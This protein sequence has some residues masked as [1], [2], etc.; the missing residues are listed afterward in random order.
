LHFWLPKGTV[1]EHCWLRCTRPSEN[2]C[3]TRCAFQWSC[4]TT[5]HRWTWLRIVWG[6][7]IPSLVNN[8]SGSGVSNFEPIST[9]HFFWK[10][11]IYYIYTYLFYNSLL[12]FVYYIIPYHI[13]YFLF[14]QCLIYILD[15]LLFISALLFSGFDPV[16]PFPTPWLF[17]FVGPA[18]DLNQQT[19]AV[20]AWITIR[21][22]KRCSS[23]QEAW[24]FH[25]QRR[26]LYMFSYLS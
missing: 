10:H 17:F 20:V 24:P 5:C 14:I 3:D 25:F 8:Y 15:L 18:S 11:S 19:A 1:H 22:R 13:I 2:H 6:F 7:Q 4:H 21:P 12:R 26:I 9:E 16:G 23:M